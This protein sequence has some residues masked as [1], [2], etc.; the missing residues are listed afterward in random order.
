MFQSY[1]TAP[2]R[3]SRD[4]VHRL[5]DGFAAAVDSSFSLFR[6]GEQAV[7]IHADHVAA[8]VMACFTEA[9]PLDA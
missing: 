7:V 8:I 1:T 2:I 5:P 4:P 6:S 9:S 3:S